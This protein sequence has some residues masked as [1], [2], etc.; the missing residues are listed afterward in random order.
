MAR[1]K[2]CIKFSTNLEDT[3]DHQQ[4]MNELRRK[5]RHLKPTGHLYLG[6]YEKEIIQRELD[7]IVSRWGT[8]IKID[9]PNLSFKGRK[10]HWVDAYSMVSADTVSAPEEIVPPSK[11]PYVVL[12]AAKEDELTA[13]VSL[14]SD[15]MSRDPK[16]LPCPDVWSCRF[17]ALVHGACGGV[18]SP[19]TFSF[20]TRE[21]YTE[22]KWGSVVGHRITAA[23]SEA[24]VKEAERCAEILFRR[25][26]EAWNYP[27]IPAWAA[28]VSRPKFPWLEQAY[29]SCE[30]AIDPKEVESVERTTDKNAE[31]VMKSGKKHIVKDPG[32]WISNAIA[33]RIKERR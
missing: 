3:M 2:T 4:E 12:E 18:L 16:H 6:R 30:V 20:S 24:E 21:K 11:V 5:V 13:D 7:E 32:G 27:G 17:M 19:L 10:V 22:E 1:R 25:P 31:I 8:L 9:D 26:S 14:I 28:A 15:E 29:N 23:I 33:K